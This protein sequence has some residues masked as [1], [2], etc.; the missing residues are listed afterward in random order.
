MRGPSAQP[1]VIGTTNTRI[2]YSYTGA[3]QYFT[4]PL[5][6]YSVSVTLYGAGGGVDYCS[7]GDNGNSDAGYGGI[8][9]AVMTV[10]PQSTLCLIVGWYYHHL[11]RNID[12]KSSIS[13]ITLITLYQAGEE[14]ASRLAVQLEHLLLEVSMEEAPV[15]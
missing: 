5:N 1:T 12:I 3:S 15:E 2:T 8:V 11:I 4:V 7:G 13:P 14:Q 10:T 9:Q 6:V